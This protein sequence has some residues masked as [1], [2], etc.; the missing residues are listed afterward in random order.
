MKTLNL[1]LLIIGLLF[2]GVGAQAQF[3]T[4]FDNWRPPNIEGV[5]M[6]EPPKTDTIPFEGMKLR[7]GGDFALQ[8]Q[9]IEQDNNLGNLETLGTNLNLP[10][11]NLNLDVAMY[12]GIRLHLRTYLSSRHHVEAWVKGGYLQIDKLDFIQPNF[13]SEIMKYTR[14]KVGMDEINYG[15]A[16]F[17]RSDNAQVIFNPFVGNYIMDAFTT[18]AFGEIMFLPDNGFIGMIGFSNGKL[19][20]NVIVRDNS[21]NALSF[22]GKVGYDNR[23]TDGLRFRLT[24]SWYTNQG[25]TTGGYLYNGDRAGSRYYG[26]LWSADPDDRESDFAGRFGPRFKQ[27]TAIQ[28]NP[29]LQY[30]GLEFFGIYE[31]ASNSDDSGGGKFTQVAAEL[32]YRFGG[33]DQFYVGGRYNTVSGESNEGDPEQSV[34]RFNIGGGW[35]LTKNIVTKLEYV[36]QNYE[37][38]WTGRFDGAYFDGIVFEAAISF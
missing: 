7:V 31:V 25:T 3:L 32:L 10:T 18:E 23:A 19:N 27:L 29:F 8:F 38:N 34:N 35:F 11:A 24:G 1:K 20:Q 17:R 36:T 37:D 30:N 2:I 26:V 9:A 28:I 14:I 15:D 16:H 12:D 33:T 4:T 13:A 21:D 5:D 6:F 22:Y